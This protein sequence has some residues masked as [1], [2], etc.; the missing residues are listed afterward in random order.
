MK[1]RIE[2]IK[3]ISRIRAVRK[4][5]L[6]NLR[7]GRRELN[8]QFNRYHKM[9]RK[10]VTNTEPNKKPKN[11]MNNKVSSD[12][13]SEEIKDIKNRLAFDRVMILGDQR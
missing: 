6:R 13:V 9:K 11:Q 10:K 3:P 2:E 5:A 4:L 12:D 1:E 7:R 8:Y